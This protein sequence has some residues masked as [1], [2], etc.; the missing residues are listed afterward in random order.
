MS[1]LDTQPQTAAIVA[2]A[3]RQFEDTLLISNE[4]SPKVF[5]VDNVA[6]EGVHKKDERTNVFT[7][8]EL[9]EIQQEAFPTMKETLFN[10][11]PN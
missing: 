4:A 3:Y 2:P 7:L 1:S 10:D 5:K 11:S 9:L 8:D 6:R